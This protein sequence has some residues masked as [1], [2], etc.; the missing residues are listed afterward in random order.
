MKIVLVG[1]PGVGK[2][3]YLHYFCPKTFNPSYALTI[4][5][6]FCLT[7]AMVRNK[8]IKFQIWDLLPKKHLGTVHSVLYYGALGALVMFDVTD[9]KSFSNCEFWI[10]EVFKHNGKGAIPIILLG[11]K[12]DLRD[13]VDSSDSANFVSD[14]QAID[15]CKQ[16]LKINYSNNKSVKFLFPIQYFPL[17]VKSDTDVSEVLN[18]LGS[19]YLDQIERLQINNFFYGRS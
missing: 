6:D 15:F 3:S 14:T 7:E 11:N 1:N 8:S 18:F 4:G 2:T 10:K 12:V 9:P 13:S 19:L 16:Q 5:A 17:S